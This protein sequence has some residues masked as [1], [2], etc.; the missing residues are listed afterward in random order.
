MKREEAAGEELTI[1]DSA[2]AIFL[3]SIK[4]RY[5]PIYMLVLMM[6]II[7]AQ[8]DFGPMLVFER[9]A[10]VYALTDGGPNRGKATEMEG[11]DENQPRKDQPL[12]GYNMYLPVLLLIGLVFYLL[13]ATGTVEDE[14]QTFMEKIENSNSFSALLWATMASAIIT[15]I[16][17]C[18]QFTREGTSKL[19]LPTLRLLRD[20]L[21]S[22]C[23]KC[24][25][26]STEPE[27]RT[28]M[29]VRESVEA[30]LFGMSRIFMALIVLTLAWASGAVMTAVGADRLFSSWIME[31]IPPEWLPTVSFIVAF[32]M[33]L[34]TGT[35]WGTMSILFP[36]ILVP[37]YYASDKD[38]VIFYAVTAGIL[39]GSVAGDHVSPISDTT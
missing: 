3:Q 15:L 39:S 8:R 10:R 9:I 12:K 17:Y 26:E 18:F 20:M 5:Y 32:L 4:Y 33:A 13:V 6:L 37:T 7:F 29:N 14:E 23:K 34:A 22:F 2:F 16:F 30:F 1:K 31:G 25:G 21:P 28:L 24:K 11:K 27:P 35:S 38:E 36:L 19:Y